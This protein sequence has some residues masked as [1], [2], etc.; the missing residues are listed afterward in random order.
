MQEL[1][2][3][4]RCCTINISIVSCII[5]KN[6]KRIRRLREKLS[7]LEFGIVTY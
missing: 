1:L 6:V 5:K 2:A 7:S 3:F 4:R